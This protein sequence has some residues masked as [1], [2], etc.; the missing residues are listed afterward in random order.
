LGFIVGIVAFI[1]VL[2]YFVLWMFQGVQVRNSKYKHQELQRF[3]QWA[4]MDTE[5]NLTNRCT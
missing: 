1:L 5:E 3:L 4:E 2:V